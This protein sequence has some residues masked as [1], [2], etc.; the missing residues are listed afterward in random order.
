MSTGIIQLLEQVQHQHADLVVLT[1]VAG[2]LAAAGEGHEV[3]GAVPP[4]DDVH[5]FVDLAAQPLVVKVAAQ[6][7][8]LDRLAEFRERL[9]GW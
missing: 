7:D 3:V 6:G 8:G 2:Q 9:V 1:A 4:F 5:P